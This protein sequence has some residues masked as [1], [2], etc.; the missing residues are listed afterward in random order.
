MECC[1]TTGIG[2]KQV[3]NVC[4]GAIIGY[5]TDIEFEMCDGKIVALIVGECSALGLARGESIRVPWCKIKCIGEDTILVEIIIEECK[6]VCR[7]DKKKK[8]GFFK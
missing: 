4:D 6:C 2:H 5:V 8:K 7:D 1:S 3:I